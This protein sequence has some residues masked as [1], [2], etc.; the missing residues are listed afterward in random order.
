MFGGNTARKISGFA[1]SGLDS[2]SKMNIKKYGNEENR[3]V[4]SLL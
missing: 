4:L 2:G 1:N 3:E